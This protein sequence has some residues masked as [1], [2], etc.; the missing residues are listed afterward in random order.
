MN[1]F[2]PYSNE[3]P[4]RSEVEAMPG[5][6]VLEFG[7]NGCG[8]CRSAQRTIGDA[9]QA[10]AADAPLCHLKI[11]DGPGQP[12]GRSFSIRLWPTLVMLRDGQEVARVVRPRSVPDVADALARLGAT[13]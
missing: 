2:A 1:A 10:H 9:L 13:T 8:I 6:T 12:L 5:R 7:S 3:E 4:A 11:E